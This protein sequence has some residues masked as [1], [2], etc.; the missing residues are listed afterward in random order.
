MT[1]DDSIDVEQMPKAIQLA[2]PDARHGD[3]YII[4]GRPNGE[5]RYALIR[6]AILFPQVSWEKPKRPLRNKGIQYG[7]GREFKT[8]D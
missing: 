4:Q 7:L 5:E 6:K 2:V 3:L 8:P 1:R